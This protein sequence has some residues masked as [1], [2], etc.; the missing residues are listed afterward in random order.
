MGSLKQGKEIHAHAIVRGLH[1]NP[2]VGGALVEMYCKCRDLKAAQMAFDGVPEREAATWNAL[3]SGYTH[4]NQIENARILL[5]RMNEGGF[6]PTIYT[7][8]GI[9]AGQVENGLYESALQLFSNM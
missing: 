9:I 7:W 4:C 2:F 3:I 6:E 8:N 1:S 5:Q